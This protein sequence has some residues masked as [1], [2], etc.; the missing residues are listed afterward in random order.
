MGYCTISAWCE[1]CGKEL[2]GNSD[3]ECEVCGEHFCKDH[4]K[5]SGVTL[6]DECW[7][8]MISDIAEAGRERE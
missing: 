4:G 6:C 1:T 2:H 3:N 8:E 5:T 7:A